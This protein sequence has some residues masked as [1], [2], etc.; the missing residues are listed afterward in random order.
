MDAMQGSAEMLD[1]M[2]Q[3]QLDN[4]ARI[5]DVDTLLEILASNMQHATPLYI[6]ILRTLQ[7]RK[8]WETALRIVDYALQAQLLDKGNWMLTIDIML[9]SPLLRDTSVLMQLMAKHHYKPSDVHIRRLLAQLKEADLLAETLLLIDTL[10]ACRY[11]P[12][13]DVN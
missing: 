6:R 2:K 11:P 13:Q 3:Q 12:S 9:D 1:T 7:Y 8:L 10:I 4:A 5:G